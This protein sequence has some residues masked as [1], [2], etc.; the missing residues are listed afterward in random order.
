MNNNITTR[1]CPRAFCN[2]KL[3]IRTNKSDDR[4]FLG[5]TN[6]PDCKY[7]E[8]FEIEDELNGV[9]DAASKWE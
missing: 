4:Q 9:E 2:G 1:N 5:C 8:P 7:V 3:I 6:F